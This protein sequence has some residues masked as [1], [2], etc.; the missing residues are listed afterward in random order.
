MIYIIKIILVIKK[1]MVSVE[2]FVYTILPHI[3]CNNLSASNA[4]LQRDMC[5][6]W[7]FR[8]GTLIYLYIYRV[9]NKDGTQNNL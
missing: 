1:V 4:I 8:G 5:F 2:V 9:M 7:T 6:R 3:V